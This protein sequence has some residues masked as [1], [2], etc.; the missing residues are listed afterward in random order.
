MS[1]VRAHRTHGYLAARLDPLGTEP[2]GDPALDPE[3]L[4]L[5]PEVMGKVPADV[6]RTYVGGEI[7]RRHAVTVGEHPIEFAPDV[8]SGDPLAEGREGK[9]VI[10]P[11]LQPARV[12]AEDQLFHDALGISFEFMRPLFLLPLKHFDAS[13]RTEMVDVSDLINASQGQLR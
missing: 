11:V 10:D 5:T 3:N 8:P 1:L 7:V 12:G 6:L 9:R 13:G 2:K 4:D